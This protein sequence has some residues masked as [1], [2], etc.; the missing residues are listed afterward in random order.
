MAYTNSSLVTY[1]K[2]SPN[3]T[4]PRNHIIDTITIHCYVGQVT[5]ERGCNSSRF[6]NYDQKNGASCNY[7]VGYDGSIGLCV[8]EKD[9]SWCSSSRENDNRA[10]TIEV[11]CDSYHPYQVTDKA[12]ET[13]INLCTDICKR[14]NIK[15]L[16]W[17][18]NKSDRVNHINGCNM[19]VHRDYKNK[20]CPGEYLYERHGY[21][22]D[23]VNKKLG[24]KTETAPV[25]NYLMKGDK[26]YTVKVMQSNLIYIGY[27]C[28]KYGADGDFGESTRQALIKFQKDNSLTADGLYGEN[29]KAK[30]ETLVA[31][32]KSST[33]ESTYTK[34]QFIKDVQSAIGAKVDG[35]AGKETLSKTVTVSKNKNNRHAV[36]KP[37]QKYLNTL[38]F[39]CGVEDG[40]AGAKFDAAVKT[41]QKANGCVSDGE[42]TAQKNTWKHLLGML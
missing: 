6:V 13:L 18:T 14:N 16:K 29:S 25:R 38:G 23:E 33:N 28:G 22:A 35:I 8:E 19:T 9:R 27:S 1:T 3:R 21:I 30:L 12:L 5:A 40:I 11:A 32:K 17:S 37:I 4:S 7:V 2:I 20:A 31:A 39:S 24:I 42:I 36:V 34:S 41:Y 26:G 10:I 15:Q